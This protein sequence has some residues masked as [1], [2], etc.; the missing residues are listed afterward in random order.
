MIKKAAFFTIIQIIIVSTAFASHEGEL[1]NAV[2]D[3]N[4]A[5]V[6]NLIMAGLNINC[7]DSSGQSPLHHA[8]YFGYL[9]IVNTLINNGADINKSVPK[10]KLT[11]LH[12]AV[13]SGNISS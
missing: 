9:E 6:K 11:P 8:C 1:F 13:M 10:L 5:Q 7:E 2:K 3:G 12:G 4:L